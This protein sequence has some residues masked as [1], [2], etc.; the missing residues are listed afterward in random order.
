MEIQIDRKT[1]QVEETEFPKHVIPAYCNLNLFKEIPEHERCIGLIRDMIPVIGKD[2]DIAVINSTHGGF[3]PISLSPYFPKILIFDQKS[4][5]HI[6]NIEHNLEIQKIDNIFLMNSLMFYPEPLGMMVFESSVD[7][8]ANFQFYLDRSRIPVL[9][10]KCEDGDEETLFNENYRVFSLTN[11]QI[12]LFL[13]EELN[14]DFQHEFHYYMKNDTEFDYDNLIHLCVMVKN[15]GDQFEQ[16][17]TDNLPLIDRWTIM[18]TGSTD[19]T[20]DI[21]HRVLVGKKKGELIEMPFENFRENRNALL[22]TAGSVCKYTLMLDDTYV[23]TGDL[24]HFLNEVRGDQFSDSFSI[25]IKSDDMEYGSNRILKTYRKLRYLYKI[26]EVIDPKHNNNVIIPIEKS[27]LFDRRFDYMEKRTME[28]KALDLKL[29]YEELEDDPDNP[30]THYYLGQTYNLLGDYENAYKWFKARVEHT[31][32]GFIQEKVDAA[33]EMSR[34]ANFRLNKPWEECLEYYNRCFELDRSRPEAMYFIGMHHYLNNEFEKAFEFLEKAFNIGYPIHCQYSLKPTLSF[35]YCPKFLTLMSYK[36]QKFEI[37]YEASKLFLQHNQP[38]AESYDEITSWNK[39]YNILLKPVNVPKVPKIHKKHLLVFVADGNWKPWN[40][41][42]PKKEG[43]GGSE[44]YIA[45]MARHIQATGNFQTYVFCNCSVEGEYDGVFYQ[46]I[47]KLNEFVFTNYIHTCIVSRFTEYIPL[48]YAGYTDNVYFIAHDLRPSL[49]IFP[50]D[51]AKLRAVFCLTEW[52]KLYIDTCLP[53]LKD[54]TQSFYYGIDQTKFAQRK[55]KTPFKFIYSSFPNRGLLNL[56]LMWPNIRKIQPLASLHLYCDLDHQ[57]TN[58]T[59]PDMMMAIKRMLLEMKDQNIYYYGWVNKEALAEG[60]NT[61]DFWFYPCTFAETFCLTALE[62]AMSR[63]FVVT[64]DLAAL[65]NTVGDRGLVIPGDPNLTEWMEQ[66]LEKLKPYL[67]YDLLITQEK[68]RLIEKNYEWASKLSWKNQADKLL[69]EY[70]LKEKYE[71][72]CMFNWTKNIVQGSL[73]VMTKLIQFANDHVKKPG[74]TFR[75]LE[76]GCWTGTSLLNFV[77]KI[78]GS[79]G[80][81]VDCWQNYGENNGFLPLMQNVESL[82]IEQSFHDNVKKANLQ[83]RIFTIKKKSKEALVELLKN[84]MSFH[85]VYVDGDHSL[86]G[87]YGDILLSWEVLE[88]GGVMV[89]DDV[90][91]HQEHIMESPLKGILRFLEDNGGK[92]D[93]IHSGYQLVLYKK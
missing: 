4:P 21:I 46:H 78:P 43:L 29:L 92:I 89:I 62:A 82:Q 68:N 12:K 69:S 85:L 8:N 58:Q 31:N 75:I 23:V 83:D 36:Q 18:D 38:D 48:M 57:W 22:D 14:E 44:T 59:Y 42:T 40:G 24:R 25:F 33:F 71:Y 27:C 84:N 35:H 20:K 1:Y 6:K 74:H 81:G 91:C 70:L 15:G 88:S 51:Y 30:R 80:Y 26:H 34:I 73:E 45:E 60:W 64:N 61:A 39:I 77:E 55:K 67:T 93:V 3:L 11:S 50:I 5:I 32:T 54:F 47:E 53:L 52:H 13:P 41:E 19:N 56:L 37:G 17:L 66:A 63:T 90:F 79:V 7:L 87:S 10:M 65:Q 9:I 28:R 16:M 86:L 76:I 2:K 49:S 72:K